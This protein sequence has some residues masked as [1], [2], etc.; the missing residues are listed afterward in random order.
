MKKK[1]N[2]NAQTEHSKKLRATTAAKARLERQAAGGER[3]DVTL[4][5]DAGIALRTVLAATGE[6]KIALATR[7]VLAE[8]EKMKLPC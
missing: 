3:W 5:E 1:R 7:L 6:T 4:R 2:T 8:A